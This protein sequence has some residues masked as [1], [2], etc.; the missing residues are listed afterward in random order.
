MIIECFFDPKRDIRATVPDLSC[1][2]RQ[3]VENGVVVDS[4]SAPEFNNIEDVYSIRSRVRDAFDAVE[5]Q[6]A[7]ISSSKSNSVTP[8]PSSTSEPASASEKL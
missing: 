4:G 5:A 8:T 1:N 3:A 6:R 2:L 7:L